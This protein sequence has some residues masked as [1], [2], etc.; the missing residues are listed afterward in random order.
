MSTSEANSKLPTPV[1]V[2]LG[3]RVKALRKER[4]YSQEELAARSGLDRTHIAHIEHG[5]RNATIT[6]VERVT[7]GLGISVAELFDT[8]DFRAVRH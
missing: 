6:T 2:S 4:G 7:F 8:P 3:Q 5:R 1:L